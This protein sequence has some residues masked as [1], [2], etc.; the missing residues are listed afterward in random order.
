LCVESKKC[1]EQFRNQLKVN[2]NGMTIV[3]DALRE[4]AGLLSDGLEKQRLLKINEKI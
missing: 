4:F 2:R 3:K 1:H